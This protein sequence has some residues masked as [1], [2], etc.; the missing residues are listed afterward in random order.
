MQ[1]NS[2]CVRYAAMGLSEQQQWKDACNHGSRAYTTDGEQLLNVQNKKADPNPGL[3]VVKEWLQWRRG[4]QGK[5]FRFLEFSRGVGMAVSGEMPDQDDHR[6][7]SN[8]RS[9]DL[10]AVSTL[11]QFS[12]HPRVAALREFIT[13]WY[14]SYRTHSHFSGP[15]CNPLISLS[16][17][18]LIKNKIS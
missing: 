11:G 15:S 16:H 18:P 9:P 10:I 5:T 4:S 14:V 1:P 7:E 3:E 17:H 6:S 2:N 13:G 8:L 12:D